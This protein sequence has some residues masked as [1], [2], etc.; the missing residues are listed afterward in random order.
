MVLEFP[1]SGILKNTLLPLV[2][3][4][5]IVTRIDAHAAEAKKLKQERRGYKKGS[6]EH[7]DVNQRLEAAQRR[8]RVNEFLL[9]VGTLAAIRR[10][11]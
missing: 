6:P 10:G 2:E 11:R 4:E 3:G 5:A 9:F 1:G 7:Q 8:E